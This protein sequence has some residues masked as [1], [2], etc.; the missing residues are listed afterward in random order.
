MAL[1][2]SAD[3]S[4]LEATDLP[5][6]PWWGEGFFARLS[7]Q[8]GRSATIAL[9]LSPV[10]LLVL[11]AVRL[12]I[13]ANYDAVTALAIASSGGYVDTLLGTALPLIPV[14]LPYVALLLML[15]GRVILAG[16]AIVAALL[17]SPMA[18]GRTA[19]YQ[20]VSLD[21]SRGHMAGLA[22]A[23]TGVSGPDFRVRG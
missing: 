10:G 18:V 17:V 15:M 21:L 20:I 22:V 13:I 1:S 23:R 3:S 14:F 4:S 8:V 6:R 16:I 2:G 19:A 7:R 11:S 5:G 9:L 12:L